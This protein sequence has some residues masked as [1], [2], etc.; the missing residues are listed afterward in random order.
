MATPTATRYPTDPR[1]RA[2]TARTA[3]ATVVALA[4]A[5][6]GEATVEV[7]EEEVKEEEAMAEEA[8]AEAAMAEELEEVLMAVAETAPGRSSRSALLEPGHSTSR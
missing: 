7:K 5:R 6:V 1:R 2:T 8:M 4:E 3:A